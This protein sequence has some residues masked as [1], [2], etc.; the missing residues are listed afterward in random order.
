[1]ASMIGRSC[2]RARACIL[3]LFLLLLPAGAASA[4]PVRWFGLESASSAIGGGQVSM[5]VGM[6]TILSN[7]A[8]LVDVHGG[9]WA[10]LSLTGDKLQ[11][12]LKDRPG[13]S[14]DV[15]S[16]IY[17]SSVASM[18]TEEGPLDRP[19]ATEDLINPR[20]D[21]GNV[22]NLYLFHLLACSSL[23]LRN[24]KLGVGIVTPVHPLQSLSTHYADEREQ[25]FSNRLH[26]ERFGEFA[27]TQ[28]ILLTMAQRVSILSFG[29]TLIV[30]MTAVTASD[31]YIPEGSVQN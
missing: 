12:R 31:L 4:N 30:D 6:G 27:G 23:G 5:A 22:P 1:M 20:S 26:F 13:A 15:D 29:F 28:M 21:S 25:F 7:P 9:V 11:I 10:G 2:V 14:Y 3:L 16:S 24:F 17:D 19:L 18:S 8:L